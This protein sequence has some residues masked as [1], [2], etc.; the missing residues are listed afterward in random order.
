MTAD[1]DGQLDPRPLDPMPLDAETAAIETGPVVAEGFFVVRM[2]TQRGQIELRH[3]ESPGS[4]RAVAW[5][6]GAGG[7]WDSPAHGLYP[8]LCRRLRGRSIHSLRV[9]FRQPGVLEE[10]VYD[11]RSA[12]DYLLNHGVAQMILVGHSF[13]GAVIVQAAAKSPWVIGSALIATQG[14]GAE[15]V[16]ILGPRCSVFLLHGTDDPV[17]PAQI[18]RDLY[19]KARDPKRIVLFPG[20]GHTLGEVATEAQDLVEDW[21]LEVFGIPK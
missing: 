13:G 3:Y 8:I 18:S 2:R 5:V 1:P 14:S 20:A 16:S 10:A 21:V 9:R 19:E 11:L 6:G 4:E 12:E 7:G 17:L 15:Q